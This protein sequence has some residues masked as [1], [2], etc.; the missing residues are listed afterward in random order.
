MALR[1]GV[2]LLH[3][4]GARGAASTL[5]GRAP[6]AGGG[7]DPR[8]PASAQGLESRRGGEPLVSSALGSL[9]TRRHAPPRK[10][11]PSCPATPSARCLCCARTFRGP[12]GRHLLGVGRGTEG[13]RSSIP[14]LWGAP[15]G[16]GGGGGDGPQPTSH[17]QL[18][19]R[20]RHLKSP[21][22]VSAGLRFPAV[23]ELQPGHPPPAACAEFAACVM[24]PSCP[25]QSPPPAAQSRHL[26]PRQRTSAAGK[27]AGSCLCPVAHPPPRPLFC[28]PAAATALPAT[29]AAEPP[30]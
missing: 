8:T 11:C 18:R 17:R 2:F 13:G 27:S 30:G 6:R 14:C 29:W 15:G 25:P 3:W 24:D 10:P 5:S 9:L 21:W 1:G 7:G 28:R 16:K 20:G 19:Y 26:R 12:F 4:A 23:M 22:S